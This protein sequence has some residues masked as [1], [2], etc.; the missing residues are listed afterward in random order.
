MSQTL[1]ELPVQEFKSAE[2]K[3]RIVEMEAQA[4]QDNL[5]QSKMDELAKLEKQLGTMPEGTK[6]R[7]I[8]AKRIGKLNK[9]LEQ[10]MPDDSDDE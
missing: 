9:E 4:A 5:I 1:S 3:R 7:K 8:T 2:A 6:S 10:L